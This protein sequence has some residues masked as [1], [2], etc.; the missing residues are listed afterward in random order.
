M[1][2]VDDVT[3]T[4]A[5][6]EHRTLGEVR[7]KS[8]RTFAPEDVLF[9]KI[10]PCMENGKSA[11]V[12]ATLNGLGFGST[13]FH[14]LR[15]KSGINPRFIWHYVRQDS[16]RRL[17]ENHMTGSVGQLRV[18]VSFLDGFPIELPS[19]EL[20]DEIVRVLDAAYASGRSSDL[21]LAAARRAIEQFRQGV[22][23]AAC[24][25]R[26]T[27]DWRDMHED[28]RTVE[29]AITELP[30]KKRRQPSDDDLSDLP[31]PD[32][33]DSYL[34]STVRAASVA[35]EY[36]TSKRADTEHV[37]VPVLR[38]GNIQDGQ[39]ELHDL[40]YIRMDREIERL[41]LEDGDLLFNRTNS[42]ELVGK[43][44][45]FHGARQMTFASYLIRVRFAAD[46]AESDFV[47][48]WINSAWGKA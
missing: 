29:R 6:P 38:M 34:V 46:V 33:P 15:P 17:A 8:Y 41:I 21:H 19:Q 39:L 1:A 27:G 12:P 3:G 37:G 42:P 24:S 18:P 22:L 4:V 13:E 10:T 48:F 25:G 28:A 43:S 36:G 47:N 35:L 7:A 20:Q 44:A 30:S 11:V 31:L 26:L 32:L 23:A 45:I 40:K 2:A 14:V 16:F 9:A 5:A